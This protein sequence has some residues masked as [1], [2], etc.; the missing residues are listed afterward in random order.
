MAQC[1]TAITPLLTEW[2]RYQSC[3][4]P[5]SYSYMYEITGNMVV[6][7]G[8]R[9]RGWWEENSDSSQYKDHLSRY[10]DFHYKDETVVRPSDLYNGNSYTVKTALLYWDS[11]PGL[12]CKF[13]RT[14]WNKVFGY[15]IEIYS[16][17]ITTWICTSNEAGANISAKETW[18]FD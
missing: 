8:G 17:P 14:I 1:K 6:N 18:Y 2:R 7:D 11:P 5:S 3:T 16:K 13:H 10:G 15:I 12:G 9:G 4:K